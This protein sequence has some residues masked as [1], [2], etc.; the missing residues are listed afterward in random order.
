MPYRDLI[1]GLDR[2]FPSSRD[3]PTLLV[4]LVEPIYYHF[5]RVLLGVGVIE[6]HAHPHFRLEGVLCHGIDL[7][8]DRLAARGAAALDFLKHLVK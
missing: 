6:A 8:A 7:D 5:P 1:R 4:D 3:R 2:D